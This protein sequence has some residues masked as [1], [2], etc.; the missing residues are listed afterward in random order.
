MIVLSKPEGHK[1][2][3]ALMMVSYMAAVRTL[4]KPAAVDYMV[5][6]KTDMDTE[7]KYLS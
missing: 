6:D 3:G 5:P 2:E 4:D 1:F 7:K